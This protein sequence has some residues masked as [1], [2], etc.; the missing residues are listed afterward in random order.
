M[1]LKSLELHGFKSFAEKTIL[2]FP[3]AHEGQQ[4][5][6]AIVGPNG[7]GK[8]NIADAIRWVMGEQSMKALRGKK[9]QEIIFSGSAGKGKMSVG[10]VTMTL[11]NRDQRMPVEYEDVVITRRIDQT[12]ESEYLVNGNPVRLFD[13][14]ILF[15]QAQFGHGSYSIIGQGM[16]DRLLTQTPAERKDFFD[17]ACGIKEFQIKRHQA[18]L[19]LE[20]T[21]THMAE[22]ELLLG[23]ITPRLK[24]LSRQVKKLEERQT[25]E[26]TLRE[27]QE[28]YYITLWQK[29]QHALSS[30]RSEAAGLTDFE[31]KRQEEALAIEREI[32]AL[33]QHKSREEQFL[34]L[35][36]SYE[37][38]VERKNI[39]IREQANLAAT[40]S[41]EYS[42]AGN[43]E[44]GWMLTKRDATHA[45]RLKAEGGLEQAAKELAQAQKE[46]EAVEHEMQLLVGRRKTL[47]ETIQSSEEDVHRTKDEARHMPRVEATALRSVLA[48]SD[49]FGRVHG[50]V[51]T[52]ARPK[53]PEYSL[54]LTVAAGHH[55]TSIV[56]EDDRVAERWIRHLREARLGVATF[57]PKNTVKP[58]GVPQGTE[59]LLREPGVIGLATDL[60][61]YDSQFSVIFSFVFGTTLIVKS[62]EDARRIGIGRIRMV[63]LLGDVLETGGSMKGGFRGEQMRGIRFGSGEDL[64]GEGYIA[65]KEQALF[66]AKEDLRGV[67]RALEEMEGT[68]RA[69][70]EHHALL[71]SRVRVLRERIGTLLEE[72]QNLHDEYELLSGDSNSIERAV[73]HIRQRHDVL[74]K[75]LL[76]IDKDIHDVQQTMHHTRREE[77]ERT[78]KLFFLQNQLREVQGALRVLTDQK[79]GKQ[80]EIARLETKQEDIVIETMRELREPVSAILARGIQP[81]EVNAIESLFAEIQK[82]KYA[83]TLIGGIDEEVVKEYQ[84]TRERHDGL[85]TQLTDLR[86]AIGDLGTLVE[87]LDDIMKKRRASTFRSIRKEFARYFSLLFGGG[88]ADIVEIRGDE[89]AD[90]NQLSS[91]DAEAD[92][93]QP[94]A[95]SNALVGIDIVAHP[96]GKKIAHI[97][98]LSGGERTIVSLA[99]I[100]AILH[101]NPAPF[102]VLD[103]V[104]AA[105]DEANTVKFGSILQELSAASQ[106]ILITHNR[107]TM[108]IAHTL[109]GVTMGGDGMSRLVSVQLPNAQT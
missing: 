98:A 73:A 43:Q 12:G 54:A 18:A 32:D 70:H 71:E 59:L 31:K 4:R 50:M 28:Q 82:L 86:H 2:V 68:N 37:Q 57:L 88:K 107:A 35:Q 104:E 42:V 96:P 87:E 17:E 105:L 61:A 51:A 44:V 78:E 26:Q 29:E 69:H 77:D 39:W 8:S 95:D 36:Q 56:T 34:E 92:S 97:H 60:V 5:I 14:Q 3:S 15:A 22:A 55:L 10:S 58:R 66:R 33:A 81:V 91:D 85:T 25:L 100:S 103:E 94:T 89:S 7:S 49:V 30:L 79:N 106:F 74:Q 108:H 6:A 67:E 65:K 75:Q 84:E 72:E 76:S 1:Y 40:L 23:E 41:R 24:N 109:Y 62:I 20:R 90:G 48:A 16:I 11:D 99:L 45:E 27:Y 52:L 80:I 9:S 63:T 38:L 21:R 64:E 53:T 102:V 47:Q 19:K 13:L 93:R 46:R 83:L 101:T